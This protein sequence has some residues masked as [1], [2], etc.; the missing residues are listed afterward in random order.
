MKRAT[1]ILALALTAVIGFGAA[2]G[3]AATI[4]DEWASVKA[5][6][7][8][9]LKSATVDPKTTALLLMDFVKQICNDKGNPLCQPSLPAVKKLLDQAR[10]S[11]MLVVYTSIPNVPKTDIDPKIA[12]KGDEPFVQSFLDK[13]LNT[14]LEKI[15]KDKGIKTIIST[16]VSAQGAILTTSS[17]AAQ[18]GFSVIVPVDAI[19]ST[20]TTSCSTWVYD[21]TNAPVI[22]SHITAT[23]VDMIKF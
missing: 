17:E 21:L 6:A 11:G 15:L 3:H 5:P 8:P 2:Q 14:D 10:A 16:G 7:A 13:F 4:I 18:K 19:S 12:P 20:I 23:S 9:A 1:S 22:A